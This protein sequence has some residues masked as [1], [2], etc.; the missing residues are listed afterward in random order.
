MASIE[1]DP[2]CL[3][4]GRTI[5]DIRVRHL[6]GAI[7]VALRKRD[8]RFDTTPEPDAVIEP[9]DVIVGVGTSEELR[10]LEDLFALRSVV[11]K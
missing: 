10:A 7:V 5:R 4:A 9:G 2:S 6:T 11:G 8:G 1:V 3:N